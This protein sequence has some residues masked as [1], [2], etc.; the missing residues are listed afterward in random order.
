MYMK[1]KKD[2]ILILIPAFI[3]LVLVFIKSIDKNSF[4]LSA[5]TVHELSL[6]QELILTINDLK[7]KLGRDEKF[8]LIDLRKQNDFEANHLAKAINIPMNSLLESV[9]FKQ[10]TN[11]NNTVVLYSNS[12]DKTVKAWILLTQMGYDHIYVLDISEE[13]IEE[14]ILKKDSFPSGDEVLKYKFQSD[15]LI[16]LD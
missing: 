7:I 11:K 5:N 1:Y 12:L 6:E 8:V 9:E 14:D 13:F 4:D 2:I 3:I 10:N 15:T 16:K